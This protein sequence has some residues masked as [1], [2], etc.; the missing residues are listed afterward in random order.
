MEGDNEMRKF[1]LLTAPVGAMGL[2]LTAAQAAD[3]IP[4]PVPEPNWTA[5]HIG[6]GGGA[7][8]NLYDVEHDICHDDDN[9]DCSDGF[10]GGVFNLSADDL[11]A[12]Y[13]FGTVEAGFDFDFG[14]G[15]IGI[16][17]NY[18]FNGD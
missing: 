17:G 12:F 4:E 13:G 10:D 11:G 1:L 5:F 18:D 8:F 7:G 14:G 9:A 16:L 15:V 3:V 2:A 6:I